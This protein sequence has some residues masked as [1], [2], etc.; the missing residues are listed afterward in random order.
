MTT[1]A[2]NLTINES[3]VVPAIQGT[4]LDFTVDNDRCIT[5]DYLDA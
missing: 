3:V 4:A 1:K 2:K 5:T